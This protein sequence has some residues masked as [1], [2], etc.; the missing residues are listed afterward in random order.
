MK[1]LLEADRSVIVAADVES[2]CQ[3]QELIEATRDVKGIEAYKIGS[4]LILDKGL[5]DATCRVLVGGH[6]TQPE[7][8]V[9]EGGFIA[10]DAPERIFKIAIECAGYP[11]V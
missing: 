8:L 7:F 5:V 2:M 3:Y 10:D 4:I 6:M 9:S 1:K 11:A